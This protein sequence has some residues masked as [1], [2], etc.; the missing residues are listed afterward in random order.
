MYQDVFIIGATGKVGRTLVSQIIKNGDMDKSKHIN[1]TRI[2]GIASSSNYLYSPEGLPEIDCLNFSPGVRDSKNY[3]SLENLL[4]EV[5]IKQKDNLIFIDVTAS[6]SI[7]DFHLKIIRETRFGIVTANK[8]PLTLSNYKTFKELT[9]EPCKYGYRCSVMA[10]AEAV[11]FLQDLRDVNDSP[12]LIE[13]CFSGTIGYIISE[14]E[15]G[16]KI[17]EAIRDA[18]EKGYTEPHPR[19][20]LNGLDVARKLVILARTS[21]HDVDMKNVNVSPFIPRK[22]FARENIE[23]FINS[24]KELDED[25]SIKTKKAKENGGVLRYVARLDSRTAPKKLSVSLQEVSKNSS[26]GKLE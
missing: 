1:P 8:N 25:F 7:I 2:V 4:N 21:G 22:Y 24:T 10:G 26:L 16:K 20:D 17:S 6:K 5:K 19:D 23:L 15:K 18:K 12:I 14:L 9:K 13:G 11:N 3:K